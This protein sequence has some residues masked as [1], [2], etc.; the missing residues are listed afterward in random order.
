MPRSTRRPRPKIEPISCKEAQALIKRVEDSS[1]EFTGQFEELESALGMLFLGPLVGWKVILLLHN[2]RTIRKYEN[3]LGINIRK[4]C[5]EVGPYAYKSI[6][7]EIATSINKFWKV[8][9][10][11][12]HIEK[13][14]KLT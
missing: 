5:P 11:E 6:G 9:S 2:K 1:Y 13:R 7:Y 4:D 8:V 10:G 12:E 14:R 3:I